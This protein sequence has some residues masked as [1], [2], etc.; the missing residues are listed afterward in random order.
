MWRVG[1]FRRT[2]EFLGCF[3]V[4]DES[5]NALHTAVWRRELDQATAQ[6]GLATP[7][8]LR[9][10]LLSRFDRLQR[11]LDERRLTRRVLPEE[12]AGMSTRLVPR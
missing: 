9:R 3:R 11:I 10:A 12:Q 4:H 2:S 1:R 8:R 5:K 6:Y 7:G